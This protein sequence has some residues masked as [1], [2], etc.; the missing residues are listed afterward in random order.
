MLVLEGL[1][2]LGVYFYGSLCELEGELGVAS[3][4]IPH[5]LWPCTGIKRESKGT[6]DQGRHGGRYL[7]DQLLHLGKQLRILTRP[8]RHTP[9]Q[10]HEPVVERGRQHAARAVRRDVDVVVAFAQLL[11]RGVDEE[12]DVGEVRGGPA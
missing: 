1:E 5:L 10:Q 3:A 8:L 7:L 4:I 11:A 12:P 2:L 6:G 9:P